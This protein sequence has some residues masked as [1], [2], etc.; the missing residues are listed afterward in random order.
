MSSW[1]R[2]TRTPHLVTR[3]AF[4]DDATAQVAT[5]ATAP[6]A[7][8][9]A[10]GLGRS[11]G[12][13]CLN[14]DGR[15]LITD[16]LDRIQWLDVEAGVVRAEAG[17]SLDRLLRVIV[18][19]GLFLPVTPGTKFVTLGGAVANDVHG[20]NHET[21]GT[22]GS[23]VLRLGLVRSTGEALTLSRDENAALFAAT[24]GGLGLTGFI[25]WVELR[26]V[27]IR[28]ALLE[29]E[30]LAVRDLDDF[31]RI[32]EASAEWPFTV[33]WV[34]CFAPARELG[35]GLFMRSRWAEAGGLSVHRAARGPVLPELP[36]VVLN[37]LTLRAFNA[38]YRRRPH[39]LGRR[40]QHYDPAFYPLDALSGWNR[41]YGRRGFYQH[42]SAVPAAVAP[43][44]V[45]RLLETTAAQRQ[46][47]FLAVLKRLGG[48]SSPGVLSFPI[49]GATLALD[50]PDRGER[51]RRLMLTLAEQATAAGGRLYPAKDAVMSP[52]MFR[53]GFPRW[54][55]VE[56]WRDPAFGSDFWRRVTGD[57][58]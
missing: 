28:S 32:A 34:D 13:V 30:T 37:S 15:L 25:A 10:R 40:T 22:F 11:Y 12:D 56:A 18:P 54:R 49:E 45:R 53:A 58:A 29:T 47:S 3:P 26:L 46:G 27:P 21:A 44:T 33:A 4:L 48:V 20:K 55:E 41:L 38:L 19:R 17:I 24:I 5:P 43:D 14:T 6:V 36:G 8:L 52:E 39:A 42:Q 35:R 31:F 9:L 23:H 51:T 16:R 50:F 7:P 2:R 57:A 1:G